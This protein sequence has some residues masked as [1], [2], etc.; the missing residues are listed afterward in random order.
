MDYT[1]TQKETARLL[2]RSRSQ[3]S[4][5]E[6]LELYYRRRVA[7]GNRKIACMFVDDIAW[8]VLA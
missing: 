3:I 5:P 2:H 1:S 8:Y 6:Q 4:D 7:L